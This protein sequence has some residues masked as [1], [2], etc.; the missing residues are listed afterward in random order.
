MEKEEFDF[1][2]SKGEDYRTE[3]KE[4][5]SGID[6]DMVAFSNADG[7]IILVGIDDT[8]KMKG[9]SINNKF[10]AEI[11]SIA[12]NCD[13]EIYADISE[14]KNVL[15]ISVP[16]SVK[17]PHRCSSGFYLRVGPTSQKLNVGEIRELFNRQGKLFFEEVINS[18]FGVKYFNK[19]RFYDFLRKAKISTALAESQLLC[20][21][22]LTNSQGQFKNIAVLLFGKNPSKFI[23]Q[24]II[25]CVLYKGKDK[26]FI[27]DKKDFTS[28]IISNYNDAIS[29]LYKNLRLKYD[30][31]GFGPRKE[32]L[33][34]PE[35]ALKEA[36]VNAICH[37]DYSEKG[38][39]IQ[40]DIFD[41]KVEISNPGGLIIKES[42]F[43]R[44]SLSRN[45]ALFGLLQ[46]I[47]LV[48]HVGSGI[49][50][51]RDSLRKA[52][53]PEPKFEFTTFFTVTFA[54]P[55]WLESPKETVEKSD[56]K[57]DR[58]SDQ[59]IIELIAE[60]PKITIEE[61]MQSLDFSASG[62][63]KIIRK[64]KENG[65]IKRIGPDKGGHW[66]IVK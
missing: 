55:D 50:R 13:P 16:E 52:G 34:I 48:E 60:N 54:R 17:K 49:S 57:S 7:G 41:D 39:V 14:F 64:L 46:R 31:K 18:E 23:P 59:K 58:K 47:E 61:L 8:G 36:V 1:I 27:I 33:E 63:K 35:E 42:D 9:I 6:K 2:L 40:I 30:I 3:F 38:A 22:G 65:K 28:D 20:N 66:E 51:I 44:K 26:A 19:T 24:G 5:L 62:I 11:Q 43:G 37:R 12:R 56:Q 32:I 21:L 10:K 4:N 45:P 15:I 53:L 25:T 29:F